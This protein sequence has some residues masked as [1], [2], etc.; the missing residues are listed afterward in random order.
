MKMY[1]PARL[2]LLVI[3]AGLLAA[4]GSDNKTPAP[5][6]VP[7]IPKKAQVETPTDPTEKMA[8]AV[9]I[10]KSGA[11]VDLK[12]D[13]LNKPEAGKPIEIDLAVIPGVVLDSLTLSV[14][15]APGLSVVSN[16]EAS[17][18]KLAIGE[19]ARQKL[20]V[21]A[22]RPDVVYM[23][24]T[25]TAYAVGVTSTRAFAIPL[26]VSDPTN[27]AP[28]AAKTEAAK[29]EAVGQAAAAATPKK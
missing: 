23:T 5:Q 15:T 10:G 13:I 22:E 18:G 4:C 28:E 20:I 3:G 29:T 16:P 24:I 25:A 11:A 14:T 7:A 12:Y 17:F 27:T 21:A 9:V 8:H 1:P 6:P 26:I 2:V 19:A